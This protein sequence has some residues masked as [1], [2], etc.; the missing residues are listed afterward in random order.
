MH[1]PMPREIATEN[2][3]I[4]KSRIT[5]S[6]RRGRS[7]PHSYWTIC[8]RLAGER[9]SVLVEAWRDAM[10]DGWIAGKLDTGRH[11]GAGRTRNEAAFE[12]AKTL[13]REANELRAKRAADEAATKA[14]TEARWQREKRA[15]E[16]HDDLVAVLR[17]IA[18]GEVLGLPL[19]GQECQDMATKAL[20]A[21][22]LT[23]EA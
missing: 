20:A 5:L 4:Y 8:V 21:H 22:H 23:E 2:E 1:V 14:R 19:S 7:E 3:V 10:G 9:Y 6:L 11:L 16:A 12:A 18:R 15:I 13:H 17:L